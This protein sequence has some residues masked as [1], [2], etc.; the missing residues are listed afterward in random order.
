MNIVVYGNS[1]KSSITG[2]SSEIEFIRYIEGEIFKKYSGRYQYSQ[3]HKADIIIMAREGKAYG[4]FNICG[5][6]NPTNEDNLNAKKPR[7]VYLV[8]ESIVFSIPVVLN[9]IGISGYQFGKSVTS[10]QF[11]EI[12]K[13]GGSH[14]VYTASY[15]SV[16]DSNR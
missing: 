15:K 9:S 7:K 16:L 14:I 2:F 5:M 11:D 13:L 4:Y 10:E 3:R 1:D 8:K 12:K 6:Q